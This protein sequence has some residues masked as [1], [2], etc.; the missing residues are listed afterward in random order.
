[1]ETTV[2]LALPEDFSTLCTIY[3]INPAT[4]IQGFINQVFFPCFYSNPTGT[5][6][7]ATYFFLNFLDV[8]EDA[9]EVDRELEEPYLR[10]FNLRLL[11]LL[12]HDEEGTNA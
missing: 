2:Q 1:M 10:I 7:W 3:Q 8:E 5:D 11:Q 12:D 9:Y 4:L 6:R